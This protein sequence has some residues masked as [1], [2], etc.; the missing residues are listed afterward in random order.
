M[1][2]A[3]AAGRCAQA[4]VQLFDPGLVCLLCVDGCRPLSAG[5]TASRRGLSSY[6]RRGRGEGAKEGVGGDPERCVRK[7]PTAGPGGHGVAVFLAVDR[8]TSV[9]LSADTNGGEAARRRR[10]DKI[11]TLEGAQRLD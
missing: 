4:Q 2:R 10:Q 11:Q 8:A 9:I 1:V 3:W 6:S 5:Q 7:T